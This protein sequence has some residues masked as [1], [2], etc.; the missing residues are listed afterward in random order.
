M[1]DV[2]IAEADW[3]IGQHREAVVSLIDAYAREPQGLGRPLADDVRERLADGLARHPAAFVLLACV[4][5]AVVG[6]AV[7]FRGYSTF[8]ARP[9]VNVH[10]LVVIPECRGQGIGRRLLEAVCER[11][12]QLDCCKVT[13]EV[14]ECNPRAERLYR[15]LGFGDPGNQPTRFLDRRL[16]LT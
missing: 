13:L 11:A 9:L 4:N 6:I 12:R 10:D 7:C 8:A 3:S 5:E 2:V 16:A 1:H 15:E 14:L